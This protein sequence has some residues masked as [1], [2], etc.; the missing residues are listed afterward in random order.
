MKISSPYV[1]FVIKLRNN[2]PLEKDYSNFQSL[3]DEGWTSEEALSKLKLKQLPATGQENS[4]YLAS[5]WQQK[6][7]RTFKDSLLWYNNKHVVP[8][9][10]AMQKI[11]DFYHKKGIH[12]L[13]LG[14]GLPNL[15]IICLHKS[16]TAKIYQFTETDK[17]LSRKFVQTWLVNYQL[18]LHGKL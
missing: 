4:Q 18:Y 7:M 12:M 15:A 9:L 3:I 14:C 16:I 8:M 10:E 13:K 17:D 1:T 2:N 5:V 6:N 11:V